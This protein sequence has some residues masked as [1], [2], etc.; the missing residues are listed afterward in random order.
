MAI[1]FSMHNGIAGIVR[2]I[3]V[4]TDL[5]HMRDMKKQRSFELSPIQL[6][7]NQAAGVA[8]HAVAAVSRPKRATLVTSLPH[9]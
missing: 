5:M 2:G 3:A 6:I 4:V 7:V 9:Y 8:V 1:L